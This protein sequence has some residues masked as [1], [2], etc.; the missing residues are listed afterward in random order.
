[1]KIFQIDTNRYAY[2]NENK[3][4]AFVADVTGRPGHGG[5]II[6]V[7]GVKPVCD[8]RFPIVAKPSK[9]LVDFFTSKV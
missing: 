8:S 4:A 5:K 3:E 6:G 1:M 9:V 7:R 2:G